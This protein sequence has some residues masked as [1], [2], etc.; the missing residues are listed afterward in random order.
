MKMTKA[1]YLAQ[2]ANL[3]RVAN[4]SD[5]DSNENADWTMGSMAGNAGCAGFDKI[6][7]EMK[8]HGILTDD[9]VQAFY[10]NL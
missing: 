3:Y 5:N 9:E 4:A 6:L 7:R 2:L 8:E 10:D 1:Q